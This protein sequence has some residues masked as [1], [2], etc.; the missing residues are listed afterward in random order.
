MHETTLK[1]LDEERLNDGG[2]EGRFAS[3]FSVE[4]SH[5]RDERTFLVGIVP[6]PREPTEVAINHYLA[7]LVDDLRILG[8]GEFRYFR[9]T[10]HSDD[11]TVR[12]AIVVQVCNLPGSR[13]IM[14]LRGR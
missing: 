5:L 2:G 6:G 9:T 10:L 14:G 13:E 12:G 8:E 1:G 4:G 11:L 3:A 7:P